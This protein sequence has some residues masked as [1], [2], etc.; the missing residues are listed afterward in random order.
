MPTIVRTSFYEGIKS[1]LDPTVIP[2]NSFW[3]GYNLRSDLSGILRIREGTKA[4]FPSLGEGKIQ[5]ITVAFNELYFIFNK[6]LYRFD[7]YLEMSYLVSDIELGYSYND[8]LKFLKWTRSGAEILY[9]FAG[10]SIYEFDGETVKAIT[11]YTPAAGEEPNMLA[12]EI[13]PQNSKLAVLRASLSQ[14]VAVSGLEDSPNTVYLSAP[15]DITY[16]PLSQ[17][18]QLPDDGGYI[19]GI[20]NWYN[21]LIIFRNKDIWAFFGTDLSD[22]SA[23]LVLQDNSVGCIA[24][25]TI[26]A[27]PEIGICFVGPDNIYALQGVTGVENQA[28][29]VPISQDI[30][31]IL[32]KTLE[33]GNTG[34]AAAIYNDREYRVCFPETLSI[35]RVFRL[36][37][38]NERSWYIDAGPNTNNFVVMDG[39]LYGSVLNEGLIQHITL[40]SL[41]DEKQTMKPAQFGMTF[42]NMMFNEYEESSLY[43][44]LSAIPFSI[45]FR[46]ENLQPGPARIKRILLYVMALGKLEDT[47]L[48]QFGPVFNRGMFGQG[49]ANKVTIDT[50]TEQ[51]F[52]VSV[53]VDGNEFV[54]DD[55][56][57]TAKKMNHL[58]I[59]KSEPIRVYEAIIRPSL[60]GHYAQIKIQS[61]APGELIAILGYGID[62]Q[63]KGRIRGIRDGVSNNK[64]W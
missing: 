5:A 16:F 55:L 9:I 63:Q 43:T 10:D 42:N 14:R 35:E 29:A 44:Q 60:K 64:D 23:A 58:S 1:S 31:N 11:P 38:Q 15:L 8:D 25:K 49:G 18:L 54:I 30:S 41:F 12:N 47:V 7:Q 62:Y 45:T 4:L 27:V 2:E 20:I 26:V 21:A 36:T 57:I 46:R 39:E 3:N 51:H 19:T 53:I 6:N 50:T 52:D 56:N 33:N 24:P 13:G 59:S 28:R 34:E 17:I 32:N 37:F 48:S 61:R 22:G 40:D